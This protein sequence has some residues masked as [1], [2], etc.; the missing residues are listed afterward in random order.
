MSAVVIAIP[1]SYYAISDGQGEIIIP[2][3]NIGRYTLHFWY[4]GI[5]PDKL[6]AGARE[7]VVS[8]RNSTLGVL[9]LPAGAPLEAHK[10]KYGRDYDPPTPP[11]S[12]YDQH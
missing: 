4:D 10:N 6:D 11:A 12:G 9:Q 8:E 2:N 5:A 1:T 7:V 3:V